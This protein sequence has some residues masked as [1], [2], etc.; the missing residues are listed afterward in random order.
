MLKFLGDIHEPLLFIEIKFYYLNL[1]NI[2]KSHYY[3]NFNDSNL[4]FVIK[5]FEY[6]IQYKSSEILYY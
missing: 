5:T 6:N 3:Y 1:F 4:D 2:K